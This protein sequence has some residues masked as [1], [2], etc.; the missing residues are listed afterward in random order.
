MIR[1]IVCLFF[2]F[3]FAAT[4]AQTKVYNTEIFNPNVKT[5]RYA[6]PNESFNS[7][8]IELNSSDVLEISFDEL[9]HENH[10]YNYRVL[11]CNADWTASNLIENE[12]IDGFI[13]G[14]ITDNS[15]SEATTVT[16]THY[17]LSIPNSNMQFKISGNYVLQIYEDNQADNIVAQV[18]FSIVEPKVT[19]SGTVRGNTDTELNRRMQQ[20]DFYVDLAGYPI[21]DANEELRITVHQNNRIDNQRM[22]VKPTYFA[23]SKL[24]YI[25]NRDLIFEGG[26]EYHRFDIS[27]VYAASF[28]MDEIRYNRPYYEAY[29]TPNTVQNS[30]VYNY[31]P[32]VNGRFVVNHQEAFR[33]ANIE[34]DYMQVFF[35]LDT[36]DPFFDGQV[37]IGGEF[38]SNL[39]NESSRMKYDF[40]NDKYY[41]IA[42]LKQG[43]YNYQYWFVPK[44]QTKANLEKIEGSFWQTGNEYTIYVYY[45]PWG[46]RYDRL[47]GVKTIT[48][49]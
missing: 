49:N 21:R 32:D 18:C 25:N 44:G 48:S 13:S 33:D 35:T 47:I 11:H 34:A 45:R 40:D 41:Y 10:F 31:Q 38:N 19:I 3:F 6:L 2:T 22:N 23:P 29:L 15:L 39:I 43:G 7:S 24:S 5:L 28:G 9:S 27:S 26:S 1:Y 42:M 8:L 36:K 37:Y 20:L 4:W 16:Y 17:R 12:Y 46:E 14:N 30:N